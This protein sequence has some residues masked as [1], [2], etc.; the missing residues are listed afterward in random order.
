MR[1]LNPKRSLYT[2]L[3]L[4]LVLSISLVYASVLVHYPASMNVKGVEPPVVFQ[5]ADVPGV[6]A[7]I[8]PHGTYA[9]VSVSLSLVPSLIV[10]V[11]NANFSDMLKY[12]STYKNVD[13]SVWTGIADPTAS[14]DRVAR[15]KED[16]SD[17]DTGLGWIAQ[18][19]TIP[20]AYSTS[21]VM[22]FKIYE[23]DLPENPVYSYV[24]IKFGIYDPGTN[25]WVC[26][27]G[28]FFYGT[29]DWLSPSIQCS[30]PPGTYQIRAEI[31]VNEI[32]RFDIR[33]DYLTFVS[34]YMY[35][36]SGDVLYVYN[37]DSQ[38]YYAKL[39]LVSATGSNLGSLS[40]EIRLGYSD[41]IEISSGVVNVGE[42]SETDLPPGESIPINVNCLATSEGSS[43]L[44]L[45]L[46]YCT[47]PG[48]GG[49]CV[50]YP[51]TITLTTSDTS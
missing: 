36:F 13:N 50:F 6:S 14:D 11:R 18:T 27:W 21:V 33:I 40:C 38:P 31:W 22:R 43:T 20:T 9:S 37:M 7:V 3:A 19:V 42:T 5:A 29:T 45:T 39:V 23:L 49:A 10:E 2:S 17:T 44:T 30:V 47:L 26:S 16:A 15:F 35:S 24:H 4:L 8:S 12:W 48:G 32:D 25:S 41:P 28:S 51:L 34:A 46:K 1:D